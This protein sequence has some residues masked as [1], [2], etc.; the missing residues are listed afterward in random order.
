[1]SAV[2]SVPPARRRAPFVLGGVAAVLALSGSVAWIAGRGTES[3]DDAFVEGHVA[4]VAARNPGQVTRV[5]VTDNAHVKAGDVLVELDDREANVRLA[6]AQADLASARAHLL[7]IET[8]LTLTEKSAEASL[9]QAR[10]GAA[11]AG[12]MAGASRAS[13][14][15][16][17][18]EVA[19]AESRRSL[20]ELDLRRTERLAAGGSVSQAEL[21]AKSALFGQSNAALAQAT[22]RASNAMHGVSTAGGSMEIAR[23]QLLAAQAGPWQVAAARAAVAVAKAHVAQAEAA[24]E[25]ARLTVSYTRIKAHVDGVVSRRTVEVGQMVDPAR[26]LLALTTLND[27]WI[28]ANFKE[29]QIARIR[30]GQPVTIQ[31]DAFP[32]RK[33]AGHVDSLSGAS[34]ARFSLLPPDNASGNFTKVVQRIPVLI[35]LDRPEAEVTLR[36]G[37]STYVSVHVR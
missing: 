27:V 9:L 8:Q 12:A 7:A 36:P 26:P 19:A 31:V 6:T 15:Q 17:Q 23:G 3:T 16:A 14:D 35:R 10:G 11:Q 28:V 37:M 5:L 29:S 4:S 1:M 33:L 21:D 24:I 13:V 32:G 18:A 30:E 22:A 34:G 2:P 25:Q 20:A